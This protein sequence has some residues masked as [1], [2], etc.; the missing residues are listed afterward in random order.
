[1][2]DDDCTITV[3]GYSAGEFVTAWVKV[4]Q[5]GSGGHAITWDGDVDFGVGDDQPGQAIGA[6]TMFLLVSDVGDSTIYGFRVGSQ[7]HPDLAAHDSIGL[8]TDAELAAHAAD[9][10]AHHDASSGG[11][12]AGQLLISDSPSTPLV[13]A[14]LIQNEAQDDLVYAD[15]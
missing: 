10:D 13:F 12:G 9:P 6:V 2:L 1:M 15:T 3:E 14:D 4:T 5:D 7:G 8:A 11:A